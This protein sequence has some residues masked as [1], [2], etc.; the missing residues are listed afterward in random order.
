MW[1]SYFRGIENKY[2]LRISLKKTLVIRIDGRNIT[3]NKNISLIQKTE[4]SFLDCFEKTIKILSSKYKC[5]CYIGSDEANFIFEEPEKVLDSFNI[6]KIKDARVNEIVVLF[7]QEFF[8]IFND[9]YNSN[10]KVFWHGICFSIEKEKIA[11]YIKC[12]TLVVKDVMSAYFLKRM[13]VKNAGKIKM[14][15]RIEKNEEYSSYEKVKQTQEGK[16]YL[17]GERIDKNEYL[18]NNIKVIKEDINEK[19]ES[20]YFDITKWDEE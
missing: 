1:H 15:E 2:S 11:S 8:N 16:L 14:E 13:M 20:D 3:K 5:L 10:E 19:K 7:T 4:N 18:N 12:R 9:M 6:D 17:K